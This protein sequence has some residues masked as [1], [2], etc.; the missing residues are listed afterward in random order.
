MSF[1]KLTFWLLSLVSIALLI[2]GGYFYVQKDVSIFIDGKKTQV[3]TF[4]K[5]VGEALTEAN[6]SVKENDRIIPGLAQEI[7]D[8]DSIRITRAIPVTVVADGKEIKLETVPVSVTKVLKMSGVKLGSLDYPSKALNQTVS[9]GDKI[10][11]T[12]VKQEYVTKKVVLEFTEERRLDPKLEKGITRLVRKGS[13]GLAEK[14]I[15]ITYKDGKPVSRTLAGKK[16][17]KEPKSRLIAMGTISSASRSGKR[18]DFER[19]LVVEATAYTHTGS[20]TATG[21]YPEV[22]TVAVDPDIIPL[23][24]KL[25]IEGYGFAKAQDVGGAIRGNRVDVFVDTQGAAMRWGRRTVKTY[26]LK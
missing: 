21:L 23:G 13:P 18:F 4:K 26:V 7:I 15:L 3:H 17:I 24:S 25:Y 11:V 20:R 14:T 16:I 10:K 12:R 9:S 6:I 1:K 22:G 19:A 8:K 5:T 2:V